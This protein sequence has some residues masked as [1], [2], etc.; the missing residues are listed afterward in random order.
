MPVPTQSLQV[1]LCSGFF[2]IFRMI[3]L[4]A[5]EDRKGEST[6]GPSW[7]AETNQHPMGDA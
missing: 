6:E 3:G 1:L 4:T 5:R 2:L 7:G